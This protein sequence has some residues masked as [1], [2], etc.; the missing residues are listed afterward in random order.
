[1][2]EPFEKA[3]GMLRQKPKGDEMAGLHS[4]LLASRERQKKIQAK[5]D[6]AYRK[7]KSPSGWVEDMKKEQQYRTML[8]KQ[9]KALPSYQKGGVVEE[10]GPALVH[11][12]EIVIPNRAAAVMAGGATPKPS[13]MSPEMPEIGR[14]TIEQTDNGFL[15]EQETKGE[16]KK[17]RVKKFV[18]MDPAQLHAHIDE[19]F[20]IENSEEAGELAGEEMGEESGEALGEEEGMDEGL[21][22]GA[23]ADEDMG[24]GAIPMAEDEAMAAEMGAEEEL[25]EGV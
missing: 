23:E 11:E 19:V 18:V 24:M 25:P 20:G 13:L 16:G 4:E 6:S 22:E 5:I 17:G 15:I 12:G 1:M 8:H 2:A 7:K 9:G 3:A 14:I 10:T 21:E